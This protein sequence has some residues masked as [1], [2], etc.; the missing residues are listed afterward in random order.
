MTF[1]LRFDVDNNGGNT[2]QTGDSGFGVDQEGTPY[3][4]VAANGALQP[5]LT[6]QLGYS[7]VVRAELS[8]AGVPSWPSPKRYS[9]AGTMPSVS[10][11]A[12]LALTLSRLPI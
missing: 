12:T 7:A 6:P 1:T 5:T 10:S 4:L 9:V 8:V 11:S 2:I 3:Q